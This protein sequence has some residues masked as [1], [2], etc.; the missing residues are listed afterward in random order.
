M[1]TN[2]KEKL[3]EKN[4]SFCPFSARSHPYPCPKHDDLPEHRDFQK[5]LRGRWEF[6]EVS[7]LQFWDDDIVVPKDTSTLSSTLKNETPIVANIS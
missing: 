7:P 5:D 3:L 6:F 2:Q 4:T 1:E